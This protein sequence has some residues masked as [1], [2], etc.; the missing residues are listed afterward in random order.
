[1]PSQI[2]VPGMANATPADAVTHDAGSG[3]QRQGKSPMSL[4]TLLSTGA[5]LMLREV[6][7]P[8]G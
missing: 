4:V 1:M 2:S 6:P 5:S 3:Q 8:P 7:G